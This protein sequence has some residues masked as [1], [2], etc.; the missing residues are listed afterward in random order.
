M[1]LNKDAQSKDRAR[2]EPA[3]M[4][5]LQ[6]NPPVSL[7]TLKTPCPKNLPSKALKLL[8]LRPFIIAMH[9]KT[10]GKRQ[11]KEVMLV[12]ALHVI[13]TLEKV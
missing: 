7:I 10:R 1:R 9:S 4:P 2:S 8:V 5:V 11:N 12:S 6:K 13:Q 3:D